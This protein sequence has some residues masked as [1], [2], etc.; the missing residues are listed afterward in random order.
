M[1]IIVQQ[2]RRNWTSPT[3]CLLVVISLVSVAAF[4]SSALFYTLAF[5][6]SDWYTR[7]WS[8]L[9]TG[10][11]HGNLLHL[12]VNGVV[13]YFLGTALERMIGTPKLLILFLGGVIAGALPYA[14]IGSPVPLV[15]ASAGVAAIFA[16]FALLQPNARLL[17][18]FVLPIRCRTL[19]IGFIVISALGGAAAILSASPAGGGIAHLAHLGG[20]IF[21]VLVHRRFGTPRASGLRPTARESTWS[22]QESGRFQMMR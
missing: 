20:L 21:G 22:G 10:F 16:L 5:R 6:G 14:V 18:F 8:L 1:H 12:L 17:L 13:L 19:L 7:P 3:L 9:T 4:A 2:P 11:V 15:G